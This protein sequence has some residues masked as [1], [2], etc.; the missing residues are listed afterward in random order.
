M[1]RLIA[2]LLLVML[3]LTAAHAS[4]LAPEGVDAGFYSWTGIACTPAVVLCENLSVYDARGDQG[5][6]KVDTLH[7][8][9]QTI[10]VIESWDGYAHIYY[11]DGSKTGW[12]H[13]EYLLMD[14]AWYVCDQG[15]PVYAC[16]ETTAP[17]VGYLAAGT[18][19]PIISEY[20]DG[21]REWVCVS[22]R[23]ASG[24]I[25]K[26][27]RDTTVQSRFRPEMLADIT[28]VILTYQGEA[29]AASASGNADMM[30]ALSALLSRATDLGGACGNCPF[31]ATLEVRL[32]SGATVTLEL[33]TDSCCI[34]RVD[35]RCYQYAL[36]MVSWE[37]S[38]DNTVLL[39]IF[40]LTRWE[41]L[42]LP[43]NG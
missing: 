18:E 25:R 30:A 14:P 39:D 17:R 37:G 10:P 22:L 12:V 43:A 20:N 35:G 16:P 40:D 4:I 7:Y 24:W 2:L 41:D 28:S 5:G 33:A 11:S 9:G 19:L 13:S 36:D 31:G 38:L 32:A 26:T 1:K 42:L 8:T 29:L 21:R 34:Y 23:G 6:R 15:T 27:A 3:P